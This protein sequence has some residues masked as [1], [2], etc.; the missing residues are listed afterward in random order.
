M[1]P[2]SCLIAIAIILLPLVNAGAQM[3]PADLEHLGILMPEADFLTFPEAR[4]HPIRLLDEI[5][6][7][8]TGRSVGD[9]Q[10]FSASAQPGEFFVFQI[11][12]LAHKRA[13]AELNVTWTPFDGDV[14]LPTSAMTCFNFSGIDFRGKAFTRSLS[15]PAGRIQPLWF[16]VAIPE[17]AV[18]NCRSTV[19]IVAKG[20]KPQ[21]VQVELRIAG[22]A[23]TNS[24]FNRGTSLSRLAW[25]NTT[26]GTNVNPTKDMNLSGA[27]D[28]RCV[29]SGAPGDWQRRP[30]RNA[31][32]ILRTFQSV[33]SQ[34]GE[35][36]TQPSLPVCH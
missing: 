26:L 35:G 18:G 6:D 36:A 17:A 33:S 12:V 8:W 11:G 21:T 5:P 22:D 14:S 30:S 13:L 19:T 16:G 28:A 29:S 32:I 25:L 4:E 10:G 3:N 34:A 9:F 23:V 15:V 7:G 1:N 20:M 31:Y 2:G 24:G 27:A